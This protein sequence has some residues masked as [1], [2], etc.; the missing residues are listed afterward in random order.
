MKRSINK[1]AVLGAGVMGATIAGHLANVG[2]PTYLLDIVP[3]T[4][5]A[6]EEKAGLT[7]DSPKVR[8]RFAVNGIA[9]LLKAKPA[10]LYIPENA[11]LLTPGN[12]EDNLNWLS[13]CDLVIEVVLERLDIKQSLFEK[14]EK[15]WKPGSIIASNTSGL[16]INKMC[17]GRSAEFKQH[18]IGHTGQRNTA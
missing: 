15:N 7:L 18:F 10:P 17:E 3:P 5:N 13:E 8:N 12:F 4:L 11:R 6:D 2:I 9:N 14:V 1:A 16:S